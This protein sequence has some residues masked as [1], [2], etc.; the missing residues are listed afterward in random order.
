MATVDPQRIASDAA[1]RTNHIA[2]PLPDQHLKRLGRFLGEGAM[3]D[4]AR[5]P[6]TG[7]SFT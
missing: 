6:K 7:T 3:Q 2:W 4:L 1:I 5:N